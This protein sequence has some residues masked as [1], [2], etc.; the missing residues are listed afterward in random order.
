MSVEDCKYK[1]VEIIQAS[2]DFGIMLTRLFTFT[3]GRMEHSGS[4]FIPCESLKR[5]KDEIQPVKG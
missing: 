1:I 3:S 5:F 2:D 4:I